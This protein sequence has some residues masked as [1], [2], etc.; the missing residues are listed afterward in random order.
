VAGAWIL[1]SL[2]IVREVSA[3][4]TA[5]LMETVLLPVLRAA[6]IAARWRKAR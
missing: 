4:R 1:V 5:G 2:S 3:I 6:M